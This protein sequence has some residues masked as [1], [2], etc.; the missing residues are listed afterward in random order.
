MPSQ[1]QLKMNLFHPRMQYYRYAYQKSMPWDGVEPIN[2]KKII[3]YCEQG[4]GEV[5]QYL[6]YIPI[7]KNKGCKVI[8]H[9]PFSLN[10]LVKH[11]NWDVV[12]LDKE[13]PEL[14]NHD[15]HILSTELPFVLNVVTPPTPYLISKDTTEINSDKLKIGICWETNLD[16]NPEQKQ[17]SLKNFKKI[18]QDSM[19]FNLQMKIQDFKLLEEINL[20]GTKLNTFKDT[21]DLIN[22]MDL[23]IAVDSSVLHLAGAMDKQTFAILPY[24]D[25]KWGYTNNKTPWYKSVH[26]FRQ[27]EL[28]NWTSV[29]SEVQKQVRLF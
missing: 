29:F 22:A 28:G 3:V 10:E 21:A 8:L 16:A 7:L 1:S 19:L 14:P 18:S 9:C 23:V 5:I 17:C 20:Y 11:Q 26:I 2:G 4:F 13:C 6:R 12:L 15:F 27:P 25:D 24:D